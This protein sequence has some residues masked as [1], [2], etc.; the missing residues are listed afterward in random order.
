MGLL[1]IFLIADQYG[2]IMKPINGLTNL[3]HGQAQLQVYEINI[4]GDYLLFYRKFPYD[5]IL[6][7]PAY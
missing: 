2:M 6:S 3:F 1:D 7:R 5:I 4:E